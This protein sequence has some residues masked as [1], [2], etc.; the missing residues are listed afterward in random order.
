MRYGWFLGYA[1]P[2]L[3]LED[4]RLVTHHVPV[5]RSG[6]KLWVAGIRQSISKLKTFELIG[7]ALHGLNPPAPPDPGAHGTF[8]VALKMFEE[9]ARSNSEI[10]SELVLVYL[11]M[12]DDY[13]EH[14]LDPF[15][16]RLKLAAERKGLVFMDLVDDFRTLPAGVIS[17]LFIPEGE[18]PNPDAAG[19]YSVAGNEWV[20]ATLY[21]RISPNIR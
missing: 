8:E 6:L 20:A 16:A 21:R 1:K 12:E 7:R 14:Q 15:R 11:P 2:M 18:S 5:P 13:S 17:G 19:H 3:S 4:G 9:L 10:G